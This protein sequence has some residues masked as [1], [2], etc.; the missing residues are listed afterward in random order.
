MDV[1]YYGPLQKMYNN[2]CHQKIRAS[3]TVI[4]KQ[5][6]CSL[7]CQAYSRAQSDNNLQSAFRKCGIYPFNADIVRAEA[8]APSSVLTTTVLEINEDVP[9]SCESEK[10]ESQ[11]FF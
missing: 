9:S 10:D 7:A 3:S 5:Q 6:V 8:L 2:L 1:G 4:T 11:D